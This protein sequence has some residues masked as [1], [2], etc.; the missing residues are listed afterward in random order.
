MTINEK[1]KLDI[2]DLMLLIYIID[3]AHVTIDERITK[4]K[5][6]LKNDKTN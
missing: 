1:L 6:V 5:E 4:T 2:H 3:A